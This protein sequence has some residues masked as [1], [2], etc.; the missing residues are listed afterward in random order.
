MPIDIQ[1]PDCDQIFGVP[2]SMAGKRT[3]CRHCNAA[4]IV[5]DEEPGDAEPEPPRRGGEK[6]PNWDTPIPFHSPKPIVGVLLIALLVSVIVLVAYGITRDKT[7][8]TKPSNFT[9][10]VAP[11][12]DPITPAATKPDDKPTA[13]SN[14]EVLLPDREVILP[15]YGGPTSCGFASPPGN[16]LW[17]IHGETVTIFDR[18]RGTS[19]A[20][21]PRAAAPSQSSPDLSPSGHFFTQLRSRPSKTG[22]VSVHDAARDGRPVRVWEPY[23]VRGE[24]WTREIAGCAL[25]G[26]DRLLTKSSDHSFDLWSIPEGIYIRR[27]VAIPPVDF[28]GS[29]D[30]DLHKEKSLLAIRRGTNLEIY[31]LGDD[32][33]GPRCKLAPTVHESHRTFV[34]R[35]TP[36][37]T[38][39][40]TRAPA[41]APASNGFAFDRIE[42]FDIETK[43]RVAEWLKPSDRS[44]GV[45]SDWAVGNDM[46]LTLRADLKSVFA[47]KLSDG[48]L[49]GQIDV[50]PNSNSV[51][52]DRTN[53]RV[54]FGDPNSRP[55]RQ[56]GFGLPLRA[57]A[58]FQKSPVW[59]YNAGVLELKKATR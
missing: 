34:P 20:A 57:P 2:S 9:P 19:I 13:A 43:K 5:P 47:Y 22:T 21:F 30:C 35:F 46:I 45:G 27:V 33:F 7:V 55:F 48:K 32:D 3:L 58:N 40:V 17:T 50:G 15:G 23:S 25:L 52:L 51:Q 12:P 8:S 44:A 26:D 38:R 14:R 53:Q 11:R 31:P 42:V 59:E 6:P 24:N 4:L 36:D 41:A 37:G 54:W 28:P 1:C 18:E 10:Y 16:V 39:V 49:L 29:E 56:Y